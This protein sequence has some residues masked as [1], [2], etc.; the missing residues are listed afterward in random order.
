[1][2]ERQITNELASRTLALILE[3]QA[4]HQNRARSFQP[5]AGSDTKIL[6]DGA[7]K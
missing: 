6:E 2:F 3:L 7:I 1:M 5:T 4:Q